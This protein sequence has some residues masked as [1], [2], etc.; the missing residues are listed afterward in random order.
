MILINRMFLEDIFSLKKSALNNIVVKGEA[1]NNI[2]V[3]IGLISFRPIRLNKNAKK[4]T[5]LISSTFLK[6]FIRSLLYNL[7]SPCLNVNT[8]PVKKTKNS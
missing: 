6:Y 8:T 7:P 4:M 1:K 3:M 2:L 5:T